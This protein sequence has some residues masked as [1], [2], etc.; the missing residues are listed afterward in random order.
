MS[1]LAVPDSGLQLD[2]SASSRDFLPLQAFGI[3]LNDGMIEDMI[4][5]VQNEQAVELTLGG[6]PSF[7]YGSKEHKVA[8]LPESFNYELYLTD[9]AGPGA[10]TQRLPNPTMSIFKKPPTSL[11][12]TTKQTKK[13]SKLI[14]NRSKLA[15][16]GPKGA[17]LLPAGKSAMA[18]VLSNT[19]TRSLPSSPAL[20]GVS[21]PNPAFS[22]SQ[23]VL[24]KNKG[25]RT[26]LVHEL[27]ARDQ[28]FEHLQDVW[29]GADADLKPTVE[30]V[31]DF[32]KSTEKWT[33][34]KIYW[35]ELD[36]WNYD[37]DSPQDRQS[38][39]ENAIKAYDKQRIGT[40]DP[41]WERLLPREDR[42]KGIVLSKLQATIAKRSTIVSTPKISVQKTEDGNKSDVDSTKAKGEA[43]SRSNSQPISTKPKKIS[44]RDAQTKRLL[45]NNPKKP[46]PKKPI[47]KVK[48]TEE[49]GKRVL[50][51]EF[52]YDTDTSEEEK[53]LSQNTST[54]PKPNPPQKPAEK[55][56]ERPIERPIEKPAEKPVGRVI[57]KQ[58]EPPAPLTSLKPKPKPIVRPPRIPTKPPTS[59]KSP[60]K[61]SREDED[62]SSSS[63]AP[64]SKRIKP[65]ELPKPVSV[66]KAAKH[67]PSDASQNSRGTNSTVSSNLT[68]KS[69]N[70]SPTKSSPLATSPPTNAS[71]FDERPSSQRPPNHSQQHPSQQHRNGERGRERERDRGH[72]HG[73]TNGTS[74]SISTTSSASSTVVVGSKKRKEREP[75]D[76]SPETTP[77]PPTKKPRV[78]KEV[79]VQAR[80]FTRY[81][82]KYEAL[83]HQ[84]AALKDPPEDKLADLLEMRGRLVNMKRE[85]QR[86]VASGQ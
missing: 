16:G 76:E 31:A 36:V 17:K 6:T 74:T 15:N 42:G 40:S 66:P 24:E 4:R 85:I 20:N 51:E 39:I 52:V 7:H 26:I 50:S 55:P 56:V 80:K 70:T 25:Q 18:S 61:R 47:S 69:K 37:Y 73:S 75:V 12:I 43:M 82:E 22:A 28:P 83:H 65:K 33:L 46:A 59:N 1:I 23:Q 32:N 2:N 34:K 77:T 53:P 60:L 54:A 72:A 3:T 68:M 5:C 81:Y 21:S 14:V 84:I 49:K 71:D 78:S 8:A 41:V 57:E 27:A 67:R 13:A 38:A 9:L 86:A 29:M 44:D 79:L 63:G 58:K 45:S 35:R 48:A 64:L 19:T 62:S 11:S 10:K 30:K